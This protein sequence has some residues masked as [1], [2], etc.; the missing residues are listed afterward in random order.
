MPRLRTALREVDPVS[1]PLK[2]EACI[3]QDE[4]VTGEKQECRCSTLQTGLKF[5][6][7]LPSRL[8]QENVSTKNCHTK[9]A[10]VNGALTTVNF[11]I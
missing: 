4:V 5:S 6:N 1:A 2:N 11:S 10:R 9:I 8:H 7:Y 3:L